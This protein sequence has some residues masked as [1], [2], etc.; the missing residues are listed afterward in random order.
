MSTG[1]GGVRPRRRLEAVALAVALTAAGLC[2][3]GIASGAAEPVPAAITSI[4]PIGGT[5]GGGTKVVI[6]GTGLDAASAVTFGGQAALYWRLGGIDGPQTLSAVSPPHRPGT[7]D[8]VVTLASG[9]SL[10]TQFAYFEGSGWRTAAPLGLDRTGHTATLLGNGKVLVAGGA[11]S[12]CFTIVRG[13]CG[14]RSSAELYDP[15]GVASAGPGSWSA[16]GSLDGRRT[17]HTATL[18]D[19]AFCHAADRPADYPCGAVL[20][21]G[22]VDAAGVPLATAEIYD[23]VA[24]TWA[25]TNS[26][27]TARTN[28][29]AT[30]LPGGEVLVVGGGAPGAGYLS[31]AE[32]YEPTSRTWRRAPD[33]GTAR[34]GHTATLLDPASCHAPATP[35]SGYPCGQVLVAGGRNGDGPTTTT[36][37]FDPLAPAPD[38]LS[39][40]GAW[41][42]FAP[43]AP[44]AV[45][46]HV[47][48][49]LPDGRVVAVA[50][51]ATD[52]LD[53]RSD[54][55]WQLAAP[56]PV[57]FSHHSLTVL[58]DATVLV[59]GVDQPGSSL[60]ARFQ[61][62]GGAGAWFAAGPL[63]AA[64]SGHTAT[65][66]PGGQV[67]VAGGN[68][69][70][71]SLSSA[72]LYD[73]ALTEPAPRLGAVDPPAGPSAGGTAVT[74]TGTALFPP[75]AVRFGDVDAA[76][77]FASRTEITAVAPPQR[78]GT[79]AR[80]TVSTAAG[81][82]EGSAA[83]R[84]TY[85]D[86]TWAPTGAMDACGPPGT[87]VG[88]SSS[89]AVA[90]DPPSCH[91]PGGPPPNYPCGKVLMA[92][93][94]SRKVAVTTDGS[95][96][97]AGAFG[98]DDVG[99]VIDLPGGQSRILE[100]LDGG[101]AATVDRP[102]R[103]G[104]PAFP[105][106]VTGSSAELYDPPTRTWSPARAMST[107]RTD[108]VPGLGLLTI[109]GFTATL[110]ADGDVLV[111]G[112]D[113]Y[114]PGYQDERALGTAELYHPADDTWSTT[115]A[116]SPDPTAATVEGGKG[117]LGQ[118]ATLLDPPFCHA[119]GPP[120]PGYP[121]G[122]VLV[123]GGVNQ[124][125]LVDVD[126]PADA[127]L[128]TAEL[129]DPAGVAADGTK[130]TWSPSGP[131]GNPRYLHTATLLPD[132]E[133]LVVG[134]RG[135][136]AEAGAT[137]RSAEIYD[138]VSGRWRYTATDAGSVT[139]MAN[140]RVGHTATLLD[141][142]ACHASAG[143]PL[144][145][146]CGRV[147]VTGGIGEANA[148]DGRATAEL[149]DPA[150]GAWTALA[151]TLARG[152]VL[153]TATLL[154]NGR[155]LVAGGADP[156]ATASAE[157]FDPVRR[158]W[159]LTSPMGLVRI[160]HT[161]TLL[162]TG[163]GSDCGTVLVAGGECLASLA[164][165]CTVFA[166]DKGPDTA[167]AEL[168]APAPT[169]S[170]LSP[171]GGP[172]AGGT[173]VDVSGSG[174]SLLGPAPAVRFGD[175]AGTDAQV[176]SDSL[177][178]VQA[179]AHRPGAVEVEVRGTAGS[180]LVVPADR[181]AQF[182]YDVSHAPARVD[183]LSA[184]VLSESQ[185]LLR[186]SAVGADGADPP[187]ARRYVVKQAA[188][189]IDDQAGFDAARSLCADGCAFS[190][191]AVGQGL[192]LLVGDL[193]PAT[194]YVWSVEAV[195]DLGQAGPPSNPAQAT[196]LGAGA[197]STGSAP[198]GTPAVSGGGA[199]A[200]GPAP[201]PR[202]GHVL[203]QAGWSLIGLPGGSVAAGAG[204]RL[205]GW[206][207][208]GAGG[209]YRLQD[210]DHPLSAGQGYWARFD[211]PSSIPLPGGT[212]RT[213]TLVLGAYHASMVGNPSGAPVQ[214]SGY[215]FAARWDPAL[216]AGTGGYHISAY[217]QA[218]RLA[219][220]EGIW[221]F[222]YTDTTV[223]ISP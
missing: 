216:N 107:Q 203:Y 200:C 27:S 198:P 199:S 3:V 162:S 13:E 98:A 205:Y 112:G 31:S 64:R 52:V 25:P 85:G 217:R 218:Q 79:V 102:V 186:F 21:A 131:M 77:T 176:V 40:P 82:S 171:S 4:S 56:P 103:L 215:D 38:R 47:A 18:L 28:H 201:P 26:M 37:L 53:P 206:V 212:A 91:A 80:I 92:G 58:A 127:I 48:A 220:G 146:P 209:H 124:S 219:P 169:V 36:E 23:P 159:L 86:G 154:P 9:A 105:V 111:V 101:K 100:V 120:P 174:F 192:V 189:R 6:S 178:R 24:G 32:L 94:S 144:G 142:A 119:P 191:A 20:V 39:P 195:N 193:A 57:R 196:T 130:G 165:R 16:T 151:G 114:Q 62:A 116:M 164:D 137:L 208:Q 30:L 153:H 74:I 2:A 122:K 125:G 213:Q 156:T 223:T 43:M 182:R 170:G 172:S 173:V 121:C 49:L 141:P 210:A 132:G 188:G 99:R 97:V 14:A 63:V 211:C 73:A 126:P 59:A 181:A 179:P 81:T 44:T 163:C 5:D 118:S 129:Y 123:A 108:V 134:G 96:I 140:S 51:G 168:Y 190:P 138:P 90:I 133:V 149:Y 207:D 10:S 136:A 155:V 87:C 50:A 55:A 147:L 46:G 148:V 145:Y 93:I 66:L 1:R 184:T 106:L 69:A 8:L 67:L 12:E 180:S 84:F 161:A 202:A 204:P 150:S 221:V 65:L 34:Y 166:D 183:D 33:M 152:R 89:V 68:G 135:R 117:R 61:P 88:R 160:R 71:T 185:V 83:V 35:P 19:P 22:G 167:A 29:T 45:E 158:T 139:R 110:L 128:G 41:R 76:V 194:T 109:P 11:G 143:P 104:P 197:P 75:A 78:P 17:N 113:K 72:E 70:Q 175:V 222:S 54:G 177:V 95:A 157:V 7:V 115:G 214:V 60:T 42:P 187:P 15:A